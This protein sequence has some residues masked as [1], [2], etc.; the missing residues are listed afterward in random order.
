MKAMVGPVGHKLILGIRIVFLKPITYNSMQCYCKP[1]VMRCCHQRPSEPNL[2]HWIILGP[3][4]KKHC[5]F[6]CY[7]FC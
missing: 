6:D 5:H 3:W 1:F 2:F 4:R 7:T